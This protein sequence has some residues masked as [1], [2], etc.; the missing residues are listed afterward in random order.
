VRQSHRVSQLAKLVA[1]LYVFAGSLALLCWSAGDAAIA[2][3]YVDPVAKLPAQ[4]EATYGSTSFDMAAHGHWLTP[5]LLGRYNYYKP[6]LLYWLQAAW[7]KFVEPT[8]WALRLPSLFAGAGTTALVFGWLLFE[9]DDLAVALVGA[10]LI[11]SSHLFFSLSRLGLTDALLVFWITL[12]MFALSRGPRLDSLAALWTFGFASGAAVMTKGIAGLFPLLALGLV[13]ALS[14]ERPAWTRMLQAVAIGVAVAAPWFLYQLAVNRRW[15]W[16][17]YILT[18]LIPYGSGAMAQTTGE[19]QIGF[20]VR[21]L[22]LLDGPLL[23]AALL[24]LIW[25]RPRLLLAWIAVVL[26]AAL[27]FRYRNISYLLP[28]YPAL[29]ILVAGVIPVSRAKWAL[30]LAVALFAGKL[31]APS[32]PW[33]IPWDPEVVNPSDAALARYA[34][35]HRGNELLVVEPDDEFYSACLGLPQVRYVYVDGRPPRHTA[36]DLPY[37]GILI[38]A[39]EFARLPEM[40][41]EFER[42]LREWGLD[43]GDPIATTILAPTED[44]VGPL[45]RDHPDSDFFVP[46]AWILRDQSVHQVLPM[47]GQRAFLLARKMIHRP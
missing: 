20:Y 14:R 19:S 26:S 45:I 41:P 12:A 24:S 7:A 46:A 30:G 9:V 23:A 40:R 44:S 17:D 3:S 32:Q 31:L 2:T 25:K 21:R 8:V 47:R 27:V 42:R 1:I 28:V 22:A 36:L 6:P 5:R 37:L 34:A 43:S 35:L 10:V 15:F 11:L 16:A 29:A 39:Q 33:G 4:D 38:T 13:C 18:N